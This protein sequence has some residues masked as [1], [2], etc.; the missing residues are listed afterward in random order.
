MS[1]C[2]DLES[3]FTPYVDG[4]AH[5]G[6]CAAIE[7]HVRECPACRTRVTAEREV[8]DV[9]VAQ[10]DRLR[11]GASAE[12]RRRC[13]VGARQTV[14]VPPA[15][16]RSGVFATRRTWVPLSMAATLV[17][18]I[19]GIFFYGLRGA[20]G[21]ALA[22][23]LVVDHVKCFE[24]APAPVILPDARA[25]SREWSTVRGWTVKVPEGVV[26]EEL[27]LI[28]LRRCLSTDG[29]T[30]HMMYRWHGKPLSVY[31]LNSDSR[32]IGPTPHLVERFGQE[33]IIWSARGRTYAVVARG[34][35]SDIEHVADY[36]RVAAE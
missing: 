35:P 5:P 26:N 15:A 2:R 29:T 1:H 32:R 7:A 12:L 14:M 16:R 33:A 25:L 30:A 23:Q 10:R 31:V 3:L 19:A 27:Q 18:T 36:V 13:E 4:E 28:G 6:D 11:A 9:L 20:G 24:F 17:L 34:R 22:A 8:R 21:E